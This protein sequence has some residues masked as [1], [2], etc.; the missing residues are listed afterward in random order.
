MRRALWIS[1]AV[2]LLLPLAPKA[3]TVDE[4]IAKNAQARGSIEKL[5]A[6]KTLRITARPSAVPA[7]RL[8]KIR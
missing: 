7:G 4:I 5:R 1:L 8:A 6:I 2:I 3:Q